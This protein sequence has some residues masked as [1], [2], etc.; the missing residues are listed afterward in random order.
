MTRKKNIIMIRTCKTCHHSYNKHGRM[1]KCDAMYLVHKRKI[2]CICY[3]EWKMYNH[4]KV[5]NCITCKDRDVST[6][7]C[8]NCNNEF[9]KWKRGK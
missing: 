8:S 6:V 2:V 1:I 7:D 5:K 9:N 4:K 3:D